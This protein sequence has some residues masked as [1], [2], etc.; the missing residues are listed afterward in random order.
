MKFGLFLSFRNAP[1]WARPFPQVYQEAF[2]Q[3]VFAE[4]L[5][6][7]AIWLTEHHFVEDGYS[8]SLF[9]IASAIAARTT[10]IKIGT[11]VLL[12]PFYHPVRLAE[13]SA[14]VDII[15]NGRLMLGVSAGYRA[16][17]FAGYGIPWK[18]RAPMLDEGL[19]VLLRCWQEECFSHKG[20]FYNLTDVRVVP[21]PVQKPHPPLYYGGSSNAA[22]RR[23]ARLGIKGWAG[24]PLVGERYK[25]LV[26]ELTKHGRSADEVF[27]LC[28]LF[29][30]VGTTKEKA[31]AEVGEQATYIH[32]LYH[33]WNEEVRPLE[34][35]H[36]GVFVRDP[37]EDFAIGTPETAIEAIRRLQ[38][39]SPAPI[40]QIVVTFPV[41]GI[42]H[43]RAM[44]E[45]ELFAEKVM[46]VFA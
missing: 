6:Y 3:A 25:Q 24:G 36:G 40:E 41:A 10:R 38:Q 9:P 30:W 11:F 20:R 14:T 29:T 35:G 19:E 27:F 2:E 37:R 43:S 46:P 22:L 17:E 4:K 7:D 32:R 42:E 12:V 26:A 34:G 31:W 45:I 8:P 1:Q 16:P 39:A 15:S 21:K 44:K 13:D 18:D 23:F 28:Q 5:G 33:E